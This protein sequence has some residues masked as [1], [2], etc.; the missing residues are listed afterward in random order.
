[1][2]PAQALLLAQLLAVVALGGV[3]VLMPRR[4][5]LAI[6]GTMVLAGVALSL[7]APWPSGAILAL[8]GL[9][10]IPAVLLARLRFAPI[11]SWRGMVFL[12]LPFLLLFLWG[13]LEGA[14]SQ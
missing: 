7:W 2:S 4:L 11:G 3:A 9:A 13:A 8:A 10:C 12:F 5:G 1:M 6:C 14:S